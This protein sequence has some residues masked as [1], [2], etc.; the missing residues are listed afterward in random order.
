[1]ENMLQRY[2]F[3]SYTVD[4]LRHWTKNG[5]RLIQHALMKN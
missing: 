2:S 5:I 3:T 1:M 4:V